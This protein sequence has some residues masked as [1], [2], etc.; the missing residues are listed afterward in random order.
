LDAPR[1]LVFKAYTEPELFVQWWG[2]RQYEVKIDKFDSRPG[3]SWRVVHVAADGG[4][5]A[6][7]GVNHDVATPERICRT[8]EYEG[9]PGHAARDEC[10][11][12]Y[13]DARDERRV[14]ETRLAGGVWKMWR[15]APDF[16]QRFIGRIS[17]DGKTIAGQW[18]MS[19][20][21]TNWE[22][23]FDLTYTKVHG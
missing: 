14:Y 6:F 8:F 19:R 17:D 11:V 20:D 23:D 15:E 7:R 2:P 12:L 4:R 3:G 10:T 5:H 1:E 16:N 18:E 22:V 9:V 21:G 13:Y